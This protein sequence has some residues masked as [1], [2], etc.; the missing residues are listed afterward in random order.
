MAKVINYANFELLLR[1]NNK[2]FA[3]YKIVII[4]DTSL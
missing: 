2:K 1:K 3:K 4:I